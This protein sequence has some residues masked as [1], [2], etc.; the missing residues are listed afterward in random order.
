[1]CIRLNESEVCEWIKRVIDE[2][3]FRCSEK[4]YLLMLK[5]RKRLLDPFMIWTW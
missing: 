1:M 4:A 2:N 5:A 3:I